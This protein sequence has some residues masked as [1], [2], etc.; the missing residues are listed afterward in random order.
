MK[1]NTHAVGWTKHNI[2]VR[3]VRER[4]QFGDFAGRKCKKFNIG[5]DL[6]NSFIYTWPT[7][8]TVLLLVP[9]TVIIRVISTLYRL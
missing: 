2:L 1:W 8:F 6:V 4:V 3:N 7:S 5:C 9:H